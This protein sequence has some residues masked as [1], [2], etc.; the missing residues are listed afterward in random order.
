MGLPVPLWERDPLDNHNT[1]FLE[2][3]HH[4]KKCKAVLSR[5]S[6]FHFY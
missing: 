5:K 2:G 4:L 1:M 6:L 3:Y